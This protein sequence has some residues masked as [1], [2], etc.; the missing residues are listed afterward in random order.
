MFEDLEIDEP[1]RLFN[2]MIDM[3]V[4]LKWSGFTK[5]ATS[6]QNGKNSLI[7]ILTEKI[8]GNK[9]KTNESLFFQ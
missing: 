5:W 3:R 7:I 8:F 6:I 9:N 1:L 2:W 4:C